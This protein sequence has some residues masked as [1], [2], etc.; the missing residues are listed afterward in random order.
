MV[1]M[2]P[3]ASVVR[4]VAVITPSPTEQPALDPNAISPGFIGFVVTFVVAALVVALIFD[5]VRRIRRV[6]YRAEARAAL[7]AERAAS[8]GEGPPG[9]TGSGRKTPTRG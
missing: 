9:A 1:V 2:A 5:M 6:N 4:T 3:A 8:G 7:E